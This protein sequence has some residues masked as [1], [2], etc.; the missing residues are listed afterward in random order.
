[1]GEAIRSCGAARLSPRLWRVE[2]G[3]RPVT[4]AAPRRRGMGD[5][6]GVGVPVG[7]PRLKAI[8]GAKKFCVCVSYIIL[9]DPLLN[10]LEL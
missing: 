1:M 3:G 4:L 7:G 5:V 10:S 2:R 8:L 9:V 6:A